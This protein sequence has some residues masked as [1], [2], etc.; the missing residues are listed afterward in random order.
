M[1]EECW[2]YSIEPN[3]TKCTARGCHPATTAASWWNIGLRRRWSAAPEVDRADILSTSPNRRGRLRINN[4]AWNQT[5]DT[6]THAFTPT[7]FGYGGS[8]MTASPNVSDK[9]PFQALFASIFY[10]GAP[11]VTDINSAGTWVGNKLGPNI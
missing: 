7:S 9:N 10:S 6:G 11:K 2:R 5:T 3:E 4:G 1:D 8:F